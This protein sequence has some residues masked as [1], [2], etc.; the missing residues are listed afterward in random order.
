MIKQSTLFAAICRFYF[1][2]RAASFGILEALF[3]KHEKK[4]FPSLDSQ[5]SKESTNFYRNQEMSIYRPYMRLIFPQKPGSWRVA[6]FS[7][8]KYQGTWVFLRVKK[9]LSFS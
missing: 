7:F 8:L 6:A 3:K 2:V 5:P 9:R 1:P 4:I